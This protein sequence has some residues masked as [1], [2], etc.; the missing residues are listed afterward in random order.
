MELIF[1]KESFSQAPGGD[2]YEWV[3]AE[4]NFSV[5]QNGQYLLEIAASSKDASQ[6]HSTDDDD[7]RIALD[8]YE[9]GKYEV[10]D[11]KVSW[12]GFGTTSSWDGTSLKGR[13]KT[14]YFFIELQ[15][16]EH[17]VQFYADNVP[18]IKHL[19]IYQ[20]NPK[21][22]F[23]LENKESWPLVDV[24]RKGIPWISFVFLG[25]KPKRF[26]ITSTVKSA[27]QKLTTDGDNLKVAVNGKILQNKKALTARKYK[28]FYFSGDLNQ[29]KGDTLKLEPTDFDFLEDSVE[30]WV[31]QD[32]KVAVEIHFYRGIKSWLRRVGNSVRK[33]YYRTFA[34]S[35]IVFFKHHHWIHAADFLA[36]ALNQY[37][38]NKHFEENS[39]LFKMMQKD[40]AY[41]KICDILKAQ[42][43]NGILEGQVHLGEKEKDLEVMFE[44]TRDLGFSIHGIKK[45]VFSAHKVGDSLHRYEAKVTLYDVYDY[46]RLAYILEELRKFY[47]VFANNQL[48]SAEVSGV[49][50]NFEIEISFKKIIT[51]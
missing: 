11:E 46:D 7:L 21:K 34:M 37:P 22:P 5:V 42:I 30:L 25:I 31:D 33:L 35:L 45:M 47:V 51:W 18:Q 32:P 14:I 12:R 41:A 13:V 49:L 27:K 20:L 24:N 44:S 9:F 1:Q 28:N 4:T 43:E 3:E 38:Q 29:G 8:R 6:N 10:H 17:T 50:K 40:E 19:K 48:D 2:R 23:H 26:S 15:S 36:N 39:A 16:G